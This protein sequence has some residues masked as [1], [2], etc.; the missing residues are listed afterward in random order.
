MRIIAALNVEGRVLPVRTTKT[1]IV[2]RS[3]KSREFLDDIPK[4]IRRNKVRSSRSTHEGRRGTG[5]GIKGNWSE[6]SAR[7][8]LVAST[9][10]TCFFTTRSRRLK[11]M[12]FVIAAGVG[13]ITIF[14]II[15]PEGVGITTGV[16]SEFVERIS[17]GRRSRDEGNFGDSIFVGRGYGKLST[18]PLSIVIPHDDA[19][20]DKVEEVGFTFGDF[21]VGFAENLVPIVGA[22]LIK[23]RT[24]AAAIVDDPSGCAFP[25]VGLLA[26]VLAPVLATVRGCFAVSAISVTV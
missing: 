2:G 13:D 11:A 17:G 20:L 26:R 24:S 10:L 23:R 7:A 8:A 3:F 12:L 5:I 4:F 6:G 21:M 18:L 14:D 1:E 22:I 9:C 15:S 25:V 16:T 19:F